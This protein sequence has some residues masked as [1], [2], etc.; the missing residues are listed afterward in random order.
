M[1]ESADAL[2][3]VLTVLF[4]VLIPTAGAIGVVVD[5]RRRVSPGESIVW[6][7]G[8]LFLFALAFPLYLWRAYGQPARRPEPLA[9]LP[10][11]RAL[12]YLTASLVVLAFGS[13][14]VYGALTLLA[15]APTTVCGVG[16]DLVASALAAV[17][18]IALAYAFRALVDR[19]PA[20]SLGTVAAGRP[21]MREAVIGLLIGCAAATIAALAPRLLGGGAIEWHGLATAL[22]AMLLTAPLLLIAAFWEEV[23]F[24]GYLQRNLAH[25]W[26]QVGAIAFS[27]PLF[28]LVHG[29]NAGVSALALLNILLI[30]VFLSLTLVRTDGVWLA[31]GFHVA[32]NYTLGPIWG[33]AVS[34]VPLPSVAAVKAAGPEWL[35]GGGFGPEGS[36]ATTVIALALAVGAALA[37]RRGR[38]FDDSE[39][40]A[41]R[42]ACEEASPSAEGA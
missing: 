4:V 30:G 9:I 6:G 35:T 25:S 18:A 26:G 5:A 40:L 12:N 23:A 32:W 21:W 3:I 36:V 42:A 38:A 14:L 10:W 2:T 11:V 28:A 17:P 34:G 24:R 27:A 13:I 1:P 8:C 37:A 33:A 39:G 7:L 20:L 31:T 16:L 22:P 15:G 19:R 41:Y 29:M